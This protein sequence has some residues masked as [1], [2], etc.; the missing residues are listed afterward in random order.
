MSNRSE[1]PLEWV[2]TWATTTT[3]Q[4][5]SLG[6]DDGRVQV[7]ADGENVPGKVE[8]LGLPG[9]YSCAPVGVSGL[10]LR[11]E[12]GGWMVS[13]WTQPP[14]DAVTEECG[15]KSGDIIARVLPTEVFEIKKAKTG[16]AVPATGVLTGGGISLGAVDSTDGV[17]LQVIRATDTVVTP[18]GV[19]VGM[20]MG[21]TVRVGAA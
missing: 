8:Q 14:S 16:V 17:I 5:L 18:L 20:C 21:T 13:A 10:L 6:S 19:S 2:T 9:H 12:R 15:I 11:L 7:Q 3:T 4:D 1:N